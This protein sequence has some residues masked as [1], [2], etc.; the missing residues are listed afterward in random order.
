MSP[1]ADGEVNA[2]QQNSGPDVTAARD[3]FDG[4]TSRVALR[5]T[6]ATP[7]CARGVERDLRCRTRRIWV[8]TLVMRV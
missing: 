2:S 3:T 5:L 1:G 8:H 4:I 6:A 7:L